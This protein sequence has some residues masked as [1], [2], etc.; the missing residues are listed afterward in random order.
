MNR[1]KL[2]LLLVV[3]SVFSFSQPMPLLQQKLSIGMEL[4]KF[5]ELYPTA[6]VTPSS[7]SS[8]KFFN[9]EDSLGVYRFDFYQLSGYYIDKYVLEN[10]SITYNIMAEQT[11]LQKF[12]E[13]NIAYERTYGKGR[14][15]EKSTQER[16]CVW[17]WETGY[18][19]ILDLKNGKITSTFGFA[20]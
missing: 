14:Y 9:Y 19:I 4:K 3:I 18:I 15:S 11:P 16:R 1:T 10:V 5:Q 20:S 12:N 2:F 8:P 17:I 6:W 7:F 13:L